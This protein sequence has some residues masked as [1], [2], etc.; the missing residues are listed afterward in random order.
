MAK[1]IKLKDLLKEGTW[2]TR[3]FGEALPTMK[4]YKN[5]YNKKHNLTEQP[6]PPKPTQKGGGEEETEK[7]LKIDIPSSP[8]NPDASQITSEL[9]KILKQWEIKEY[10][11]DEIRWKLYFKEI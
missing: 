6:G 10:P 9:I 5:A 4:D 2:K 7:K 3:K 11:S 8:F 1:I